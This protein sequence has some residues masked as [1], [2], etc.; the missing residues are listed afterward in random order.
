[1][2]VTSSSHI[3]Q[4]CQEDIR[5]DIINSL[6]FIYYQFIAQDSFKQKMSQIKFGYFIIQ[7]YSFANQLSNAYRLKQ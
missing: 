7:R 1:M 5:L 3:A 2:L 4:L 6:D